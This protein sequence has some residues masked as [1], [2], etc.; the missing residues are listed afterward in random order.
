MSGAPPADIEI[1][2]DLVRQLLLEQHPH[3]A[4]LPLTEVGSGWDNVMFRL[5]DH[6][7]VRIPRR[8]YFAH[9]IAIE[10]EFL[11]KLKLFLPTPTATNIGKPS[12]FFP[13]P[14]SVVPWLP[15]ENADL[16]PPISAE[17]ETLTQFLKSLH[18]P[19]SE[20]A[21]YNP[22]R[23]CNLDFREQ[24]LKEGNFDINPF[25]SEHNQAQWQQA[26]SATPQPAQNRPWVH[27]DLHPQNILTQNNKFSAIIDWGD[28]TSGDP[29]V[30]AAAFY[31]LFLDP[32]AINQYSTDPDLIAR[33]RGW[34]ILFAVM[35]LSKDPEQTSRHAQ[36]SLQ[37]LKTLNKAPLLS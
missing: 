24:M 6:L 32:M 33:S 23:G 17:S 36:T 35:I 1:T 8:T 11:P 31:M 28:L 5:G 25:L 20:N 4:D 21:P 2:P 18:Q 14:W 26:L 27:G 9:S 37:I 7:A 3:L 19:A 16:A 15:G 34:A 30:D 22:Y 12:D 10:Q 13:Y 29:A